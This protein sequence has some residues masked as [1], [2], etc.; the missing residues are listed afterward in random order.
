MSEEPFLKRKKFFMNIDD[1]AM[2]L[3]IQLRYSVEW[4]SSKG[5]TNNITQMDTN[6]IRNCINKIKRGEYEKQ[7]VQKLP[8]LENELIYRQILANE[9]RRNSI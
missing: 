3:H 7:I 8:V 6:Y 2:K 4:V 1:R 9:A 5:I